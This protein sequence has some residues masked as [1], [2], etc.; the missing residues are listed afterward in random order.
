MVGCYRHIQISEDA[1][2]YALHRAILDSFD[3]DNDH[4]HSFYMS[5]RPWDR[6]SEYSSPTNDFVDHQHHSDVVSLSNFNLQKGD[7]FLEIYDFGDCWHFQIRVLR[8][9]DEPTELTAILK[10]VGHID[11]YRNYDDEYED[12]D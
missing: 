2:L 8:V 5:N 3:F 6:M 12:E 1:T 11:Q 7:K 10:T 9:L 4:L